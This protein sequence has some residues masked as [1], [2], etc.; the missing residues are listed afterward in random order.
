[1]PS[2][3]KSVLFL[4]LLLAPYGCDVSPINSKAPPDTLYVQQTDT[5]LLHDTLYFHDTLIDIIQAPAACCSSG[6]AQFIAANLTDLEVRNTMYV[7]QKAQIG[8]P[9]DQYGY[10]SFPDDSLSAA[11]ELCYWALYRRTLQSIDSLAFHLHD[12]DFPLSEITFSVSKDW[13][14]SVYLCVFI[15]YSGEESMGTGELWAVDRTGS[16]LQLRRRDVYEI[17]ESF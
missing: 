13:Q 14:D 16:G 9:M 12:K 6:F 2:I 11:K 3:M 10:G 17:A 5:L 1:M 4:F 8:M 7:V 15:S